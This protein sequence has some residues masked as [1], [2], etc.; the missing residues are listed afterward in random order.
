MGETELA[1]R[2][3]YSLATAAR[4]FSGYKSGR[5]KPSYRH[6]LILLDA[7]GLLR[8]DQEDN[9]ETITTTLDTLTLAVERLAALPHAERAK[10]RPQ[11]ERA[12]AAMRVAL[13]RAEQVA[14]ALEA[15]EAARNGG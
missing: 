7:A 11:V 2:F 6:T 13:Q 4:T 15:R 12:V 9:G 10:H 14:E 3:G 5:R 1:R 8:P